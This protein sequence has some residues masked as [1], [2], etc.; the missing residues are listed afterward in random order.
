M[1]SGAHVTAGG[2]WTNASDA[3][4][5]ENFRPVDG[6]AMLAKL[7]ALPIRRWNYRNE[8]PCVTHIGPTAQDFHA[9]FEVGSDDK[10]VSTVDPSGIALAAIQALYRK[11]IEQDAEN[12]ELRAQVAV[13]SQM[14][15]A[16]VTNQK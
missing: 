9:L 6:N 15:R 7:A 5:K 14:I 11:A 2:M 4:L 13:L 12:E 1:A 16:I 3:N 8:D 10:S